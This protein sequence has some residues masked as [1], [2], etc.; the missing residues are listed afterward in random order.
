MLDPDLE[1]PVIWREQCGRPLA[2]NQAM[3]P[4]GISMSVTDLTLSRGI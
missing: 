1:W 3:G 2:G 4:S